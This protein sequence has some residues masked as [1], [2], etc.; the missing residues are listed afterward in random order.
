MES[1]QRMDQTIEQ[2]DMVDIPL[3]GTSA[4]LPPPEQLQRIKTP[5]PVLKPIDNFDTKL[6]PFILQYLKPSELQVLQTACW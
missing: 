2:V 4:P 1:P 6:V 5:P 3:D